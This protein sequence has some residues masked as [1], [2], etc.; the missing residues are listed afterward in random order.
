[1][2]TLER[3]SLESIPQGLS[4]GAPPEESARR[5]PCSDASHPVNSPASPPREALRTPRAPT[6]NAP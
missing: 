1:M 5:R 3:A 4:P 2:T 6:T